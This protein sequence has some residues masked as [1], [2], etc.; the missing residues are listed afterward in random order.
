MKNITL[1]TNIIILYLQ[2]VKEVRHKL[3]KLIHYGA[4]FN[5]SSLTLSE[6]LSFPKIT[7]QEEKDIFEFIT[8]VSIIP[9]DENIAIQSGRLRRKTRLRLG[10]S[11]IAATASVSG[12]TLVTRDKKD[13]QRVGDLI[14]IKFI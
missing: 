7:K 3:D 6:L 8:F 12:S 11:I 13:F 4:K 14:E 5:I 2:G 10:D 9:V 1:D